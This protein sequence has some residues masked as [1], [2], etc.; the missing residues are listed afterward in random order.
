MR[1]LDINHLYNLILTCVDMKISNITVTS[2]T[3][4][5]DIYFN[6][7]VLKYNPNGFTLVHKGEVEFNPLM[8][9]KQAQQLF[10]IFLQL[11]EEDEEL[12]VQMFYDE[13]DTLD[14]TRIFVRT[15]THNFA[16]QYYYNISLG[17]LELILAM[18]GIMVEN[19]RDFDCESIISN[20]D[21]KTRKRTL[22]P[23]R[24]LFL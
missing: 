15:D 23:Q 9:F 22:F 18:S 11:Q 21:K 20:D 17:Y 10:S 6:D 14:R 5:G 7:R 13:K 24:D 4:R 16:S 2:Q 19:L 1:L 8:N 12:Y 3:T